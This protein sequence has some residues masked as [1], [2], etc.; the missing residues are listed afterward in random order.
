MSI[1]PVGGAASAW[2]ATSRQPSEST[3]ASSGGKATA[4]LFQP[5]DPLNQYLTA[6]DRTAVKSATGVDVRA[7]GEILC[8]MSMSGAD[9]GAVLGAVGQLA[10][11]RA[12]GN[13]SPLSTTSLSNLLNQYHWSGAAPEAGASG[14]AFRVDARA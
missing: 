1:S 5:N 3:R 10:S 9:Y 14:S 12:N 11:D 8:P 13:A 7:N 6:A 4:H 2:F